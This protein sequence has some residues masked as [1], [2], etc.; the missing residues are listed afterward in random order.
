M[1]A[2]NTISET[3]QD[4]VLPWS[5]RLLVMLRFALTLSVVFGVSVTLFGQESVPVTGTVKDASGAS[6][7]GVRVQLSVADAVVSVATTGNDGRYELAVTPGVPFTLVARLTGF[8]DEVV[9]VPGGK[10]ATRHDIRL[11][12]GGVSDTVVVTATRSQE[13]Q[14]RVTQSVTVVTA[15]DIESVGAA[16]LAD[17]IRFVPGVAVE[18]SGR[19]G[20]AT[21]LF[22]RG[23]E[24]DYNLVLIDGVRVNLSGGSFDLSRVAAGEIER[25]EIVR[26]AQSALY[27]SDAMGAVVHVITRHAAATDA[28][29]LTGSFEGGSFGTARGDVWLTGGSADRFDYSLGLAAR[30][31]TGALAD[32][33]PEDDHFDQTAFAASVGNSMGPRASFR[34]GV[35]S[36]DADGRLVGQVG[37]GILNTGG[38]A[39]TRDFN[40]Y[41]NMNHA[42]GP[43]YTG[44]ATANYYRANNLSADTGTDATVNVYALLSG[45]PGAI[46][47]NGP[48]LVRLLTASEYNSLAA[49]TPPAGQFV[50]STPFGFGDFPFTSRTQFRRPAF[51]YTGALLW[52][53]G[54]RLT[55]GYEWERERNVLVPEQELT[56]NAVFVQQQFS[57]GDRWFAAVGA[58]ID[59]KSMYDAFFSPKISAGGY[60]RPVSP[61]ALSSVKVFGNVGKG[62][63]SPSFFERFGGSFADPS[64]E[65]KVERARTMDLGVE[66]T[67]ADQRVRATATVFD[68]RYRDQIEFR[69]TSPFFAPDGKP[70]YLNI[71]GSNA[72]GIELEGALQRPYHGVTAVATYAFVPTEVIETT[73]LDAQFR[74]GQPLLRRPKHSGTVRVSYGSGPVGVH[75]DTRIV[76]DRHDSSFIGL[77]TPSFASGEISVNPGYTVSGLGVEFRTKRAATV[78]FRADNLFDEEYEGA[79]GYPGMPRSAMVGVRFSLQQ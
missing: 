57:L 35:R 1:R 20:A 59:D 60:P 15:E 9:R 14:A 8:G 72:H 68:N 65:L 39:E 10:S 63:K 4:H 49:S 37:Y 51:T 16:S 55:M 52:G 53:D 73:D 17:V 77:L 47:P 27:G 26:G 46:F 30:R 74:P 13:S 58:R 29:R 75:W 36:S 78:Y 48:R 64:P 7:P 11:Q 18:S 28:P 40:W 67:L 56:N 54:H 45:T 31:T 24:S 3:L 33:L 76:G 42:T 61:G 19:E 23:G 38:T 21:A 41:L 25:V 6:I 70:D 2:L 69:S 12:V 66:V 79:L 71:A 43:R 34:T 22:S 5:P 44:T 32:R 50:A 62:I